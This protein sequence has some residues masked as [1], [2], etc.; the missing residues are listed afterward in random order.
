MEDTQMEDFVLAIQDQ[1]IAMNNY[2]KYVLKNTLIASNKYRKGHLFPET[3]VQI[4]SRCKL[5]AGT[6]YTKQA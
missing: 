3:T 5:L 2:R 6:K 1:V 4:A